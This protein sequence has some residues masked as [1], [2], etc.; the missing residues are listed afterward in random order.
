MKFRRDTSH[1]CVHVLMLVMPGVTPGVV[2]VGVKYLRAVDH[3]LGHVTT[4]KLTLTTV[5]A[6]S[7]VQFCY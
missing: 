4:Y 7:V 5:Y 6:H 2:A 1:H 3:I